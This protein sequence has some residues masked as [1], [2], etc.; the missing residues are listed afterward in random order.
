M[1]IPVWDGIFSSALRNRLRKAVAG[2]FTVR[3]ADCRRRYG[4]QSL[5]EDIR[6]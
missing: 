3:F 6:E 5:L 1:T 4:N 2:E